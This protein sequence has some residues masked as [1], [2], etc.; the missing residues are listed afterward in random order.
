MDNIF[1]IL[2]KIAEHIPDLEVSANVFKNLVK[3]LKL[4]DQIKL[5]NNINFNISFNKES[6]SSYKIQPIIFTASNHQKNITDTALITPEHS[7]ATGIKKQKVQK[8]LFTSGQLII[9]NKESFWDDNNDEIE[10]NTLKIYPLKSEQEIEI[11]SNIPR[12]NFEVK[13]SKGKLFIELNNIAKTFEVFDEQLPIKNVYKKIY[14]S[15]CNMKCFISIDKYNN[16]EQLFKIIEI[17]E[18]VIKF[19]SNIVENVWLIKQESDVHITQ[20]FVLV[21][22][23]E[24]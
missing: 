3:E 6:G 13:Y 2:G 12:E 5:A 24:Q 16:L 11:T 15:C 7:N 17:P 1:E 23:K 18:I 14:E 4:A 8:N 9:I 19:D 22:K 10:L 20:C 21:S